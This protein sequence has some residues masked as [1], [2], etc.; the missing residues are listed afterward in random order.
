MA[1]QPTWHTLVDTV[2][3]LPADATLVTSLSDR[4]FDISDLQE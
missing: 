3:S 1:F 4:V 2:E